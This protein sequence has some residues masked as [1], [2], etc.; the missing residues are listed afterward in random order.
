MKKRIKEMRQTTQAVVG[1]TAYR[2]RPLLG[3][4]DALSSLEIFQIKNNY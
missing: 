2:T 3:L 4:Q 1:R